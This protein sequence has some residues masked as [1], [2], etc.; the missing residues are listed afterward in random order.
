MNEIEKFIKENNLNFE[1]TDS[2]LN[3]NC[4]ILSGYALYS[5]INTLTD[6]SKLIPWIL[7]PKFSDAF[8]ELTRVFPYAEEHDYGEFWNTDY[9]KQLYNF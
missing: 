6:L 4:V 9:A 8:N 7:K 3:G 2:S 5:N 1:G